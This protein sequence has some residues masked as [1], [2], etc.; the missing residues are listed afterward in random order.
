MRKNDKKYFSFY[1]ENYI[2]ST[3]LRI[4]KQRRG[5]SSDCRSIPLKTKQVTLAM[6]WYVGERTRKSTTMVPHEGA[7]TVTNSNLTVLFFSNSHI[8]FLPFSFLVLSQ[9]H[10]WPGLLFSHI[11]ASTSSKQKCVVSRLPIVYWKFFKTKK[12]ADLKESKD[13]SWL[14]F[15]YGHLGKRWIWEVCRITQEYTAVGRDSECTGACQV[16]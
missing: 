2:F 9:G 7:K 4:S 5:C 14:H 11:S 1:L 8:P 16:L 13:L 3:A 6:H 12:I 10:P 15:D